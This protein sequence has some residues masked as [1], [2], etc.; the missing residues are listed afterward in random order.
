[1]DR[2]RIGPFTAFPGERL[3]CADGK[4]VELGARAFDLLL[5]LAENPGSST[6]L[7]RAASEPSVEYAGALMWNSG[8]DVI[9]RSSDVSRIH[10]GKPSPAITYAR[11]VCMTSFERPVVP[12]VGII[13]ATSVSSSATGPRPSGSCA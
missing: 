8:S 13:T 2:I 9:R 6:R 10:H 3:L 7:A 12:D 11:C 5:V 1:M 4:P